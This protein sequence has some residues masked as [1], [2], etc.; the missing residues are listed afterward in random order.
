MHIN[1]VIVSELP[2]HF[3]LRN[4]LIM[5]ECYIWNG[6]LREWIV[7]MKKKLY[8]YIAAHAITRKIYELMV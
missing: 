4:G 5:A 7:T 2:P 8:N 3:K 1:K 6:L